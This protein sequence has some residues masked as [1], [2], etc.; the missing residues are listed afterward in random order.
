MRR[1]SIIGVFALVFCAYF[2]IAWAHDGACCLPDGTCAALLE[3]ECFN[4]G[5]E[6]QGDNT[7]CEPSTCDGGGE[8]PCSPGYWKNHEE[9]WNPSLCETQGD[10]QQLSDDLNA[11]GR[12]SGDVRAAAGT[13]LNDRWLAANG[14]PLPCTEI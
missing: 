11:K 9:V 5:G 1:I 14:S 13:T 2:V 10:C 6:F 8:E 7:T 4:R 12:G 3:G